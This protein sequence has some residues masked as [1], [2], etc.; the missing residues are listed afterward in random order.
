VSGVRVAFEDAARTECSALP[1]P[2]AGHTERRF[3]ALARW[4]ASDLSVGR[5]VEGHAD[6]LAILAEAGRRPADPAATYGVWAARSRTGGTTARLESDGWHLSGQKA[7]CSGSGFLDRALLTADTP[8]GYRLFDIAVAKHVASTHPDSWPAVGMADS[9]S[10][11]LDFGGPP[12]ARDSEVGGPGFYLERPGF[13]FGAIGV[14]ACWYGGANGLVGH[15]AASLDSATS[16]L[17]LAEL[18]HAVA[19]VGAMRR[20]LRETAREIDAD[21]LDV[22]GGGM[23]RALVARHAV[24]HGATAVLDLVASAGGART[25]SLDRAQ[26][27]RAADLYVYLAQ[28]HGPQDAAELGRRAVEG[29]IP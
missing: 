12:L 18:G 2:G 3:E 16:E 17:V 11:T 25:L 8:D 19:H 6:A 9:L 22:N 27:R 10:E 14:A 24:R 1:L 28:H 13:W 21:P 20:V 29:Q 7:F 26:S 15:L 5:L 23:A 4:S